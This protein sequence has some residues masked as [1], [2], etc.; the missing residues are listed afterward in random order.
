MPASPCLPCWQAQYWAPYLAAPP[1][2]PF[3]LAAPPFLALWQ[4]ILAHS[5]AA[6][7]AATVARSLSR[8]ATF[9]RSRQQQQEQQ[10]GQDQE[11]EDGEGRGEGEE[12][13]GGGAA[14]E[15][16]YGAHYDSVAAAYGNG[17]YGALGA[18][19]IKVGTG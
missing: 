1:L 3:T 9:A 6:K 11:D 18:K 8:A 19:E 17:Q 4:Y 2:V 16:D 10:Q 12:A 13:G 5:V 15:Y 7:R 14:A